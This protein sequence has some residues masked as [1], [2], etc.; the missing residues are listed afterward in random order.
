MY[1]F[2]IE[3]DLELDTVR[4]QLSEIKTVSDIRTDI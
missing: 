3:V 2:G 1:D 4:L